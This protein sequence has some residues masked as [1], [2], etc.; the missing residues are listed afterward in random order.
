MF[1]AVNSPSLVRIL[2]FD[3]P[4]L[5]SRISLPPIVKFRDNTLSLIRQPK[6]EAVV[7]VRQIQAD[8]T[9]RPFCGSGRLAV[10]GQ[11]H[12]FVGM[13]SFTFLADLP[14]DML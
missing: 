3:A 2:R 10:N 4:L 5:F 8:G 12:R 1:T 13:W 9:I 7:N 14:F 6:S 11:R